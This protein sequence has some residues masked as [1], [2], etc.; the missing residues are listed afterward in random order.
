MTQGMVTSLEVSEMKWVIAY[1]N[2]AK[3]VKEQRVDGSSVSRIL[4]SVRCTLVAGRP[5]FGRKIHFHSDNRKVVMGLFGQR[6]FIHSTRPTQKSLTSCEQVKNISTSV[7]K[8]E[9]FYENAKIQKQQILSENKGKSG[10]YKWINK[11]NGKFYI[12]SA[13]DLQIRLAYYYSKKSMENSLKKSKSAIYSA[14][15]KHGQSNF[16]LEILE[17]CSSEKCIKLEQKH[18]NFFKPEYNILQ[19]AGSSLGVTRSGVTRAKISASKIGNTHSTS[20]SHPNST[21]TVV[22]DLEFKTKTTFGSICEAA[23]AL[24]I[25]PYIISGYFNR[26]QIKPYKG[27]YVFTKI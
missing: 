12:G 20:Q 9:K 15:L 17:Y 21:K 10:I 19:I 3:P 24:N 22:T 1:L 4:D 25:H 11:I 23:R 7:K 8:G 16:K 26:N 2:R 6:A 18:I 27:R 14:I 13:V 5:V